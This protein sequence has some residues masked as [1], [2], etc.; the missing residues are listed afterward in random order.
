ME[1]TRELQFR[2][3]FEVK[4]YDAIS[5]TIEAET[6]RFAMLWFYRNR[7]IMIKQKKMVAEPTSNEI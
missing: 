2:C 6:G 7:V 4:T 1:A 3:D 5:A